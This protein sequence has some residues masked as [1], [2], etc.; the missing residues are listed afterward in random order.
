MILFDMQTRRWSPTS[1]YIR[2]SLEQARDAYQRICLD[3]GMLNTPPSDEITD[4]SPILV[5]VLNVPPRHRALNTRYIVPRGIMYMADYIWD[6]D[7]SRYLKDRSGDG[8]P[9]YCFEVIYDAAARSLT[10]T[11]PIPGPVIGG[12]MEQ[13]ISAIATGFTRGS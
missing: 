5:T 8:A 3:M 4:G 12:R 11:N 1:A 9:P 10:A 6:A 2:T 7:G 13:M